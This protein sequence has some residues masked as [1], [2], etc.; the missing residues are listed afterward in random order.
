MF[1]YPRPKS[2]SAKEKLE[3]YGVKTMPK[4]Y[5]AEY[6]S[7]ANPYS[8]V[9]IALV[10]LFFLSPISALRAQLDTEHWIPP[11]H[12]RYDRGN[13]Y[14]Y[15]TTPEETPFDVAIFDGTGNP[16]QDANGN[17]ISQVT[18]S[19]SASKA[20][21][22]GS[23]DNPQNGL[24]T[25][26]STAQLN[27]PLNNKGIRVQASKPFYAN[28]RVRSSDQA[29]LLTAKGK[30]AMG[31]S[32]RVG[33]VY[34]E[35][36][37]TPNWNRR[38]NFVGIMATADGTEVEISGFASGMNWM[39]E[40]G[41]FN[42]APLVKVTLNRG[43][44]YVISTYVDITR[45]AANRNGLQGALINAS[46][47][48]VVNC[49]S[50]L[51]SPFTDGLQDI[52][53]DQIVPLASTG[54]DYIVIRG[55]G[56][57]E[58]ETPLVIAT[59]DDTEIFLHGDAFPVATLDAGQLFRIPPGSYTTNQ[60]MFVHSSKP[61]YLF[62]MLGGANFK[63]TGGLNFVPPLG[64]AEGG[65][66][67]NIMDINKIGNTTY[68]GKLLIL[69]E[70][71]KTVSINGNAVPLA[72]FKPVIGKPEYM[73]YKAPNLS[74]N[75]RVDSDGSLQIGV[76][77]RNNNAG[78]AGYFSGFDVIYPPE[79]AISLS[80]DCRDT[81]FLKDLAKADSINWYR[82]G[83][84]L[85]LKTDTILSPVL[86]GTYFVIARREFCDQL[87]WDTSEVIVIPQP[88]KPS[89][90]V[91]PSTC[92][93]KG[94]GSF[95]IDTITGGYPPFS[96]SLDGGVSFMAPGKLDS[97]EAGP[98]DLL[99][100][101]S[102]GCLH[103]WTV[104]I[105][106]EPSYP[107]VQIDPAD[108]L[109]CLVDTI[110]LYATGSS[111]GSG[112]EYT[113]KTLSGAPIGMVG[114]KEAG[115]TE[116]GF[117]VLSIRQLST[118]CSQEDTVLVEVDRV[119]PLVEIPPS[120]PITC[121]DSTSL[122]IAQGDTTQAYLFDWS[123]S[124]SSLGGGDN[125]LLVK[126]PGIYTL[127][128]TDERNGCTREFISEVV[129]NRTAPSAEI[130][131]SGRLDCRKDSVALSIKDFSS[132]PLVCL[133]EL[134]NGTIGQNT[135]NGDLAAYVPGEHTLTLT[136]TINGCSSKAVAEVIMDTLAPI[137]DAGPDMELT[138][139]DTLITLMPDPSVC[140]NCQVT[141]YNVSSSWISDPGS[142]SPQVRDTGFFY[143]LVTDTLNGCKGVDSMLV[144]G[145]PPIVGTI[146]QATAPT[147]LEPT[148]S[149]A[150][151]T[152]IGGTAPFLY[153][154]DGGSTFGPGSILDPAPGGIY[155][156]T[157]RDIHGCTFLDSL[158]I[159]EFQPVQLSLDSIQSLEWGSSQLLLAKT[160]LAPEAIASWTWTPS[161]FLSCA[162]CPD[163]VATPLRS[164]IYQVTA[165]DTF[166]CID[167]AVVRFIVIFDADLYIPNAFHP[168]VNGIN[169]RFTIYGDPQKVA[170]IV[171]L[172]IYD[173]WGNELFRGEDL[174][175]NG[176]GQGW[177][178]TFRGRPLDPAVFVYSAEVEMANGELRKFSGEIH[179]FR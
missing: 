42:P 131:V 69:A 146:L 32:F 20:I 129:E 66:V 127:L 151:G 103:P 75:V 135:Q 22:L 25:L 155:R 51:G 71:G 6:N 94:N 49:G 81:L 165:Q 65:S 60:N 170:R 5:T 133:W 159:T 109:N 121:R 99:F 111:S 126:K 120:A 107:L 17:S 82:D 67:N 152:I 172:A 29:D 74:G 68:E 116:P 175:I 33:H 46:S 153:S 1:G 101:D 80:S 11:F 108:T 91:F 143:L 7:C 177:D 54:T 130:I 93:G 137:V 57:D 169:D 171:S 140:M 161:D 136:D 76:L 114:A 15:L 45:P 178:G 124:G 35:I 179:L 87:L 19:N 28:F 58:L 78:W 160:N 41:N 139:S 132:R 14:L 173:R 90:S 147:C 23:G 16:I 38:S 138:C 89:I 36:V 158:T 167:S 164:I 48:I 142:V 154:F 117:Y 44:S 113:W 43:Q 162:S 141:W 27:K 104:T 55:D 105:P 149:V 9:P 128:V 119:L 88:L 47:P 157:V 39:S 21:Y 100:K 97:L 31:T 53:F 13:H 4:V 118:G 50:W 148:G 86:P 145:T 34:N 102:L 112:F 64:C 61:V 79:V 98:L 85:F 92:P 95:L 3:I 72:Q 84:P 59:E 168:D 37:P 125:Q 122:I 12:A 123:S 174:P 26:T 63:Q 24:V 176:A 70:A 73:T 83:V 52:G 110:T 150:F 10:I 77:G 144:S 166:G 134:P 18:I 115:I 30:V 62:Q 156:M 56:P 96:I 163:P 40:S 8:I 106:L 2:L